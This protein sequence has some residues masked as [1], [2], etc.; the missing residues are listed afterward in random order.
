[1][2][3][4]DFDV[5]EFVKQF[6]QLSASE[7]FHSFLK[8]VCYIVVVHVKMNLNTQIASGACG[9]HKVMKNL[10]VPMELPM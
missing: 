6:G 10:C 8:L 2:N 7:E 9:Y 1:M 3:T 5:E 4:S